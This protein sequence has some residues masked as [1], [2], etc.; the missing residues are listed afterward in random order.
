MRRTFVC[1]A[2]L[3]VALALTLLRTAGRGTSAPEPEVGK[4]P[5]IVHDVY[6]TLNDST[7]EGLMKIAEESEI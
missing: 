6:F 5:M 3:A 1:S 2:L 4:G 7:P